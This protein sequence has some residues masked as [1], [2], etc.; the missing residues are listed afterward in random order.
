MGSVAVNFAKTKNR[1]EGIRLNERCIEENNLEQAA[2]SIG[3]NADKKEFMCFNQRGDIST[4]IGRSLKLVDK[5]IT[6]PYMNTGNVH[7]MFITHI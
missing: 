6:S 4:L 2:S 1:I 7:R 5:F 3:L